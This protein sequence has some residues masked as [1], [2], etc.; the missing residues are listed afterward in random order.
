MVLGQDSRL[1]QLLRIFIRSEEHTSELQSRGHLVCR[2]H[3]RHLHPFPTRRSSDL[4]R[5]PTYHQ[6]YYWFKKL[7]DPKRDIQFRKS[8]KEYELKYRPILSNSK[9][10]TN[11]PGTRFQIDAT[12]ADIYLV[13]SLDVNKVI[14][15]PVIYA[16]LDVYS[17]IITGLYRS[18]ERREENN[19]MSRYLIILFSTD[20]CN[21]IVK[22]KPTIYMN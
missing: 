6:F 11:G 21:N 15:R 1:T 17:R 20:I 16:V 14:G 9:S 18:K 3:P 22:Y 5:T 19:R 7:E 8:T 2:L 12:I 10:E 4:T 13:S